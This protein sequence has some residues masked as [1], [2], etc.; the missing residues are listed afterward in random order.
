M[1]EGI[2]EHCDVRERDLEGCHGFEGR[3]RAISDYAYHRGFDAGL[4]NFH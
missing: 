3:V 1:R 2:G 4:P